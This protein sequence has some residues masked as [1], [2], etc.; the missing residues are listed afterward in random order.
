MA[1]SAR[2]EVRVVF[3]TGKVFYHVG[4]TGFVSSDQPGLEGVIPP[5]LIASHVG[6]VIPEAIL[7]D[8]GRASIMRRTTAQGSGARIVDAEQLAPSGGDCPTY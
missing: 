5:L 7:R 2:G 8:H 6:N 1:G 3:E 4:V